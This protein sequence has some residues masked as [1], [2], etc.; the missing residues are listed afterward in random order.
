MPTHEPLILEYR[1]EVIDNVHMGYV[2][3]VNE[4]SKVLFHIGDPSEY[5]YYRSAS[6]PIQALPVIMR[7]LDKKYGITEEES[8]IFSASHSGEPFHIAILES[9]FAKAGLKEEMLI[10]KPTY[11]GYFPAK[12]ELL[13][14]DLP[15]R[16]FYHNCAGKHAGA[17]LL[18][19]ELGG[20]V[21]DYWRPDSPA[22][23]EIKRAV[24]AL[25]ETNEDNTKVG[26]DGCGVPVF[27]VG[28]KNIA[29]G[30]KN[31]AC[32]DTIRDEKL[33][34]AAGVYLPRINRY[35]HIIRGTG[36]L[37]SLMNRDPNLISKDGAAGVYGC[38]M[39]K[40]RLGI[41]FKMS[42]GEDTVW[43]LILKSIFTQIGGQDPQ[44]L[45]MLDKLRPDSVFNDND[46]VVGH[47]E[48]LI[49]LDRKPIR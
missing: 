16:K 15:P 14:K 39:R 36:Y 7:D 25:S 9:I 26:I 44:T 24:M 38:G 46:L 35:P 2:C 42:S 21:E 17:M 49:C 10:M 19:R 23:K 29:A 20:K 11:P 5:V 8:V 32:I 33:R 28:L 41:S 45:E 31:L 1:N 12:L 34:E 4:N 40:E 37:C 22:Q 3:I 13:K 43:P 47:Y 27:A 48:S 18:Q 30:Y 6:K